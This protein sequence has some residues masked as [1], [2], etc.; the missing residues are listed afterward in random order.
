[1][2]TLI[3][4]DIHRKNPFDLINKKRAEGID[5]IISIG[6]IDEPEIIEKLLT[7]NMPKEILIGN[8]EYPFIYSFRNGILHRSIE[9]FEWTDE[10]IK[11][12]Y[13][14][15][16]KSKILSDYAKKIL[17]EVKGNDWDYQ[18]FEELGDKRITYLHG[19]FC[20]ATLDLGLPSPLW[21]SL[22]TSQGRLN[23]ELLNHNFLFMQDQDY[24]VTFRGHDHKKDLQS[25]GINENPF[26]TS[27]WEHNISTEK[28]H[29]VSL[30]VNRRYIAT[31]GAFTWGDYAIL[32]SQKKTID[33]ERLD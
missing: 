15:W 25:I 1:M 22:K 9:L 10:E 29:K 11:V 33:F 12:K 13:E 5:R 4:A 26:M 31:V 32:D 30:D 27:T 14:K 24:W 6:D 19:L 16:H 23:G 8:H 18:F 21:G 7:L 17:S 3:L 2:K 28:K 20:S